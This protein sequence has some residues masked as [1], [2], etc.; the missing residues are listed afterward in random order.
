[1][2]MAI[3]VIII[4]VAICA[5]IMAINIAVLMVFL[6]MTVPNFFPVRCRGLD[7]NV[8]NVVARMAVP[9]G[10]ARPRHAFPV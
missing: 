10:G 2:P 9:Q 6:V 3:V 8:G 4:S 7:M 1:M 5:V